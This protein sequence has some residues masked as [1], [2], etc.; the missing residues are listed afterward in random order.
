[1]AYSQYELGYEMTPEER[2][3]LIHELE[4]EFGLR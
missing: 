3:E 2:Q 1:M 4:V